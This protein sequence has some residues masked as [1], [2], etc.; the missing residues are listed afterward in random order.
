[1][2]KVDVLDFSNSKKVGTVELSPEVFE[3]PVKKAVLHSLVKWQLAKRRRGTHKS[4]NKA[5]VSG[6]GKKPFKQKGTGN[7]RQG[8]IRSPLNPK[9]GVIFGP[10]P[11]S[12]EYTLPRKLKQAG[13]K[14]AL[15]FL[16]GQGR[17]IV[18][19]KLASE[20]GK[21]KALQQ[22]LTGMG[23]KKAVLIDAS[24]SDMMKRASKNLKSCRY[25]GVDGLNVYDLL[26][27]DA[28]VLAKDSLPS[29]EKRCG[30]G[31]ES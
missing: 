7:A 1:M 20:A 30:V 4:K 25:Y 16:Y 9:G 26:K 13:L 6:G 11:R 2:A 5:E 10:T 17:L 15:S 27:Y 24:A 29:I 19:D 31:A 23:L 8:S 21:T 22:G 3:Q 14:S 18:V 12:Y 28:V